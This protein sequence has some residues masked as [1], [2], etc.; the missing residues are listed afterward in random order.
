[1]KIFGREPA[2]IL[3][4]MSAALQLLTAFFLPITPEQAG[5]VNSAAVAGF[6]V[7]TALITR[8]ADGGSSFRT[9]ILGFSQAALTLGLVFGMSLSAERTAALMAFVAMGTS[10]FVRRVSTPVAGPAQDPAAATPQGW[11]AGTPVPDVLVAGTLI[12]DDDPPGVG[13]SDPTVPI[14]LI[15]DATVPGAVRPAPAD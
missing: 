1:M 11:A 6:G 2:I 14:A 3:G 7:W 10:V 13:L 9:A 12:P 5:A 15:R 8:A 4:F